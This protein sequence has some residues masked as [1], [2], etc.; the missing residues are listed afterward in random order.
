MRTLDA[1]KAGVAVSTIIIG[2]NL[3]NALAPIG[4]S[5]FVTAFGYEA[6]FCGMGVLTLLVGFLLLFWY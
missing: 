5:F 1:S 3:G 4:G 6:M 2:Q